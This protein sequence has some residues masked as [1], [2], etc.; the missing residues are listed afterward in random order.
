MLWLLLTYSAYLAAI[1]VAVAGV[2]YVAATRYHLVQRLLATLVDRTLSRVADSA[3]AEYTVTHTDTGR[4]A[5]P[6]PPWLF[7]PPCSGVWARP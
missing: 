1:G 5:A 2:S 4:S 6:P 7:A 3:G